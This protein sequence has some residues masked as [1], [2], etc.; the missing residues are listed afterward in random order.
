MNSVEN[1]FIMDE[2]D[3]RG[4][5][6]RRKFIAEEGDHLTMLNVYSAFIKGMLLVS[7]ACNC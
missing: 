3:L 1:V 6:E 4:E 7:L 2:G 5:I